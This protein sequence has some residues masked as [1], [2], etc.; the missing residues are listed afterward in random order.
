MRIEAEK[1]LIQSGAVSSVDIQSAKEESRK[2]QGSILIN[3]LANRSIKTSCSITRTLAEHYKIPMISLNKVT[4]PPKLIKRCKSEQARKLHFLPI[5]EQGNQIVVGMVDPLD[6]NFTDEIRAIYRK[7]VQPIFICK[8]DFERNFYRFFRQGI[9]RP[10]EGKSL[11]DTQTLKREALGSEQAE[12]T[13]KSLAAKKFASQIISKALNA[14]ASALYIEPQKEESQVK[15]LIDGGDY[16]LC[17]LSISNHKLMVTAIM[18][19]AK[20]DPATT[21]VDQRSR[22]RIKFHDQEYTL[23]Y[24]ITPTP[25]GERVAIHLVDSKLAN[26]TLEDLG[27]PDSSA[28]QVKEA[29]TE[30]GIILITGSTG[31]GKSTTIQALTRY[32][33]TLNARI[34]TIE[35]IVRQKIAG[36]QQLQVKAGGPSKAAILKSLLSRKVDIVI[37]D[38]ADKESLAV[39]ADAASQGCLVLLSVPAAGISEA[40][41]KVLRSGI[42]RSSLASTLKLVYN[43]R[44]IRKLCP[45]CKTSA[46]LHPA[47]VAQWHIPKNLPLHSSKGCD[48]CSHT[49]YHGTVPLVEILPINEKLEALINQGASGPEVFEAARLEGALTLFELGINRA[50]DGSTSLEEVLATLP[51]DETFDI[52]SRMKFG[53]IIPIQKESP[54]TQPEE[55]ETKTE[56]GTPLILT[57]SEEATMLSHGED[58]ASIA[59][60]EIS[61]QTSERPVIIKEEEKPAAP[62]SELTAEQTGTNKASI[63]LVDD[64]PVTLEFTRHILEISGHFNVDT[65]E[66]ALKALEILQEKQY[67]LVIT[68]QE[69]PEQ[70]G[71]E[72]IESIR[73]HPSLNS[74]GTILLT[75]NLNEMSALGGGAD[76]Y[77]AKPTDPELLVARA[78]SISDIYKR[79]S[80]SMPAPAAVSPQPTKDSDR[81]GK[82]EFT[83]SDMAKISSFELD[84]TSSSNL[85]EQTEKP[86]ASEKSEEETQFDSLFK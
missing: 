17:R 34:F 36:T 30:P 69:M 38:E 64:S 78:K 44:I 47:T 18:E 4:P 12:T 62:T 59:M 26:I 27:L 65:A 40:L 79:L 84:N 67:H 35:D 42:S 76:G 63:L 20:M 21:G 7:S 23:I 13:E 68:D 5:S 46:D 32:A 25:N 58:S 10:E 72:F 15:L 2:N 51:S 81:A 85:P 49:G 70:T 6:L 74:V 1:E 73:Q 33:A 39:A 48:R 9:E 80:G 19:L 50:I 24:R 37:V 61:I 16:T 75:G 56:H 77:I 57:H 29:F 66:T 3:L 82:V 14:S 43:Q 28:E 8:D 86:D 83:A 60:P 41:S 31:S 45:D 11:L 53:R 52:K 71:Q 22:R 55:D 54:P